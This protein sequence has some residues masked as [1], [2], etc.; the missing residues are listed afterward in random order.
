[1]QEPAVEEQ[2]APAE[3]EGEGEAPTQLSEPVEPGEPVEPNEPVK[4]KETTE[5]VEQTEPAEP[6]VTTY[7]EEG[8]PCRVV[9]RLTPRQPPHS[10]CC[11][12]RHHRHVQC[13][14][15]GVRRPLVFLVAAIRLEQQPLSGA[16]IS[17]LPLWGREVALGRR[18]D[19]TWV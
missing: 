3:G 11:C 19:I 12:R 7:W 15:Q 18:V 9:T 1:M 16:F 5:S 13:C 4:S 6:T 2:P 10:H 14:H 8:R 17:F